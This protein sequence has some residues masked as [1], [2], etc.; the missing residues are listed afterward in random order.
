MRHQNVF[1]H[2]DARPR[3]PDVTYNCSDGVFVRFTE[4]SSPAQNGT[5]VQQGI[6]QEKQERAEN[7]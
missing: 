6:T 4:L 7:D 5:P 1:L 3:V 2:R